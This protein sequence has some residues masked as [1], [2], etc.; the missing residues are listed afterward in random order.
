MD[1]V[2]LALAK[3][4]TEEKMGGV[5]IVLLTQEEYDALEVKDETTLYIIKE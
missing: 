2:T 3:K 4:H 1:V 5:S